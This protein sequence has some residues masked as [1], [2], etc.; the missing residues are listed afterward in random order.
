VTTHDALAG[1]GPA[2]AL[3][4]TAGFAVGLMY[5]ASLRCGVRLSIARRAW[6]PYML[7][8]LARIASVALFFTFSLRWGVPS[9]LAAFVGFLI[10]RQVA[11]GAARRVA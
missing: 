8:A 1:I 7:L 5:F 3:L 6:L 4:G 10:A 11:V 9:L 2:I